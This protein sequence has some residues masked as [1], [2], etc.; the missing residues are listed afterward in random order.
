MVD[1]V[2]AV[3]DHQVG[4][5]EGVL[6]QGR[7]AGEDVDIVDVED[8]RRAAQRPCHPAEHGEVDM[9]GEYQVEAPGGTQDRA[10]QGAD[11]AGAAGKRDVAVG[12]ARIEDFLLLVDRDHVEAVAEVAQR[13]QL[14]AGVGGDAAD[15]TDIEAEVKDMHGDGWKVPGQPA[16]NAGAGRIIP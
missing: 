7:Q 4:L 13:P 10:E 12:V 15:A 8:V 16:E 1:R 9:V 5:G 6:A 14:V 2:L 11:H 3:G